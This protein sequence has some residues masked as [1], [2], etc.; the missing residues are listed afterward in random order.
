[1]IAIER[2][3]IRPTQDGT[4][5]EVGGIVGIT[6][7]L[8]ANRDGSVT[9][10]R[11]EIEAVVEV[12]TEGHEQVTGLLTWRCV[13][14]LGTDQVGNTARIQILENRVDLRRVR[15]LVQFTKTRRGETDEGLI[16]GGTRRVFLV[17]TESRKV[18]Y[19]KRQRRIVTLCR[20][21][22]ATHQHQQI[23]SIAWGELRENTRV[24]NRKHIAG[25][26]I[27]R[28]GPRRNAQWGS[29]GEWFHGR[30]RTS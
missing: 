24:N 20:W 25:G 8:I 15:R 4:S 26:R 18:T 13:C 5:G 2:H 21:Q 23:L 14:R 30:K 19:A 16:E 3:A 29:R 12:L 27:G 17:I 10:F 6:G 28:L 7:N 11:Q 1:M 9:T 22:L